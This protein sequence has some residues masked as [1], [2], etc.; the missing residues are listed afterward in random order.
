MLRQRTRSRLFDTLRALER[1]ATTEELAADVELHRTGVRAHLERLEGA[2]LVERRRERRARGRPRDVWS[3]V[4]DVTLG[5]SSAAI[6]RAT[7]E[8][9]AQPTRA[10]LFQ[11]LTE[12]R[13]PAST[14]ELAEVLSMH[15]NGVRA[16]L[17][18]MSA[19][20]LVKRGRGPRVPGRP[21]DMWT[22]TA[23]ARV[24]NEPP[25]GYRA[26]GGWLARAIPGGAANLAAVEAE[27]REIGRELAPAG[28]GGE[29]AEVAMHGVLVSLGFQPRR[30]RHENG[31]LTYELRNCPYRDVVRENQTL[32]C[33][34]HRGIT[35]GL[36]DAMAPTTTL[37]SFVPRD[38]VEAGCLIGLR[39]P[40][41]EDVE[42]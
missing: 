30:T 13:R 22:I 35:Q 27:G 36:L 6:P 37:V 15:P 7:D 4:P 32:V 8:A 11:L 18:R 26:L 39:G 24:T 20:G 9:L 34:L 33:T 19:A 10:K 23:D 40:M 2:G 29:D 14:H 31:A 3:I 28:H 5:H 16:H 41:V 38:P 17:E 21:R 1:P 12:L 25:S 42:R